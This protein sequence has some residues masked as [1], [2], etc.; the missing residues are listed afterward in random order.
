[1]IFNFSAVLNCIK[2]IARS[3]SEEENDALENHSDSMSA[4]NTS[5]NESYILLVPNSIRF[6]ASKMDLPF[7][8]FEHMLI[9]WI[10][11][12]KSVSI[13]WQIL[14]QFNTY[15]IKVFIT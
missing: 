12:Q 4:S 14:V 8:Y 13:K 7:P 5:L 6:G 11:K 15:R 10:V 9:S 1:M 2:L 3:I